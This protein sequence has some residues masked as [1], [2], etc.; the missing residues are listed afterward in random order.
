MFANYPLVPYSYRPNIRRL[1]SDGFH[2]DKSLDL[3]WFNLNWFKTISRRKGTI[4]NVDLG[5]HWN[6]SKLL[7]TCF[8]NLNSTIL[9]TNGKHLTW[10]IQVYA[11]LLCSGL[12]FESKSRA[13]AS[14]SIAFTKIQFSKCLVTKVLLCV[15]LATKTGL[16]LAV[17]HHFLLKLNLINS[18]RRSLLELCRATLTSV[19]EVLFKLCDF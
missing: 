8:L 3:N 16:F 9:F 1:E 5:G 14:N 7:G 15:H 13:N 11:R 18:A 10:M 2:Q 19:T 17:L 4:G 6:C 12:A